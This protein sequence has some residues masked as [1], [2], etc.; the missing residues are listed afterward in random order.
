MLQIRKTQK[1]S[2][3]VAE[4]KG[5]ISNHNNFNQLFEGNPTQLEIGCAE[6]SAINSVGI[7]D[8][9][10]FFNSIRQLGIKLVFKQCSPP[11]VSSANMF[12]NFVHPSEV[13]SIQ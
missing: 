3:A 8:W 5:T 10:S 6:I 13:E 9:I 7:K 11:I 1:G 4:L 2:I 12:R